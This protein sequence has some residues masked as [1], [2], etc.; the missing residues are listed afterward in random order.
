MS[1]SEKVCMSLYRQ[2]FSRADPGFKPGQPGCLLYP[3]C[4]E[5]SVSPGWSLNYRSQLKLTSSSL[6]QGLP[7]VNSTGPL[8]S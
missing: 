8:V 4:A 6:R 2:V 3:T 1:H 5:P 7:S